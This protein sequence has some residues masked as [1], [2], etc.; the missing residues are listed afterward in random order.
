[1]S[2]LSD[3]SKV[4]GKP[5]CPT[6]LGE[7]RLRADIPEDR[8]RRWVPC[9][10]AE[11]TPHGA[12]SLG[13]PV[14]LRGVPLSEPVSYPPGF[15]RPMRRSECVGGARPCPLV[16]CEY[17]TYLR[18]VAGGK[19]IR[20]EHGER[21][22]EDVPPEDSCV[23]DVADEGGAT[24][25]RVARVLGVTRERVRQLECE[26]LQ[27]MAVRVTQA[28]LVEADGACLVIAK[29][30]QARRSRARLQ[31]ARKQERARNALRTNDD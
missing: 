8:R 30:A 11:S 21:Q 10:C 23:L 12:P 6:C 1:M 19:A 3:G 13:R 14:V 28:D 17:N 22:P 7:G 24:L 15:E 4:R 20:I 2:R 29:R 18:V 25:E 31:A 27:K 26:A 9:G 16:G 5:G